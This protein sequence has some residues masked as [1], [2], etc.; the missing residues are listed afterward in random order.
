MEEYIKK[1]ISLGDADRMAKAAMVKAA[2]LGL[3]VAV[4]IVDESGIT[5]LFTRMDN[6]PLVSVDA[7]R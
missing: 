5:K 3:A 6:S 7:S 2:E 4:T 1:S